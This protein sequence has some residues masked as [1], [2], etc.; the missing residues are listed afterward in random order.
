MVAFVLGI[1]P[2]RPTV[3]YLTTILNRM[4]FIGGTILGLIALTPILLSFII[5]VQINFGGTSLIIVVGVIIETMK[6]I[7]SQLVMRHYKGFLNS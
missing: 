3:D 2:G 5:D 1:R 7:E 6:Q 4:V